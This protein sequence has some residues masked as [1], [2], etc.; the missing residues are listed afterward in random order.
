MVIKIREN[1]AFVSAL[2][3]ESMTV[4]GQI[5]SGFSREVVTIELVNGTP[6]ITEVVGY[7]GM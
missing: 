3:Q 2:V 7:T 1:K 4:Q 6:L 5:I